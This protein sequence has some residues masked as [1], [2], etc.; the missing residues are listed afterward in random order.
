M[1]AAPKTNWAVRYD[2][3]GNYAGDYFEASD[4]QRIKGNIGVLMEMAQKFYAAVN[5][6][7]IPDVT[8]SS[9]GYAS[10]INVLEQS[11][12]EL[13]NKTF[14]PG[15]GTTKTWNGNSP[16][17]QAADLNRIESAC[18]KFYKMFEAQQEVLP[19]LAFAMGGSEF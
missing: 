17:P 12:L 19:K 5:P 9:Y 11:L 6:P 10:T 3:N 14:D 7:A 13:K 1:W 2:E 8:A 18:L 15:I 16:A 4:Y